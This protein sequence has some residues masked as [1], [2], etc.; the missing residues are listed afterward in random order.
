[1][2]GMSAARRRRWLRRC[3]ARTGFEI[4]SPRRPGKTKKGPVRGPFVFLA[5][6]AGFEP[7]VRYKRTLA[8]QASAL[9]HSAT[10]PNFVRNYASCPLLRPA[11][12]RDTLLPRV[13][14]ASQ[15]LEPAFP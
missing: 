4:P 9:S 13:A 7:A 8:F 15:L 3:S 10:S 14:A 5:E 11:D 12:S 1:M 6:K 2:D